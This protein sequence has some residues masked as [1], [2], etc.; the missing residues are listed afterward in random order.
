MEEKI[1]V[2]LKAGLINSS[3]SE[4][5]IR[6]MAKR[7]ALKVTEESQITDDF[8]NDYVEVLKELNGQLSKDVAEIVKKQVEKTTTSQSSAE[9]IE[10]NKTETGFSG[11]G[12]ESPELLKRL[13]KMEREFQE[14]I[15][16]GKVANLKLEAEAKLKLKQATN[17][18]I[19]KN[20]LA[21]V[22][23]A[24]G[25]TADTLAEKVIPIY[26]N[27][28][29]AAFGEGSIPRS[30]ENTPAAPDETKLKEFIKSK[31]IPTEK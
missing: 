12:T 24:D 6:S 1:F 19:L 21:K 7:A 23:I 4:R 20:A 5:T 17:Q 2:K 14:A 16:Q 10:T 15:K 31:G 11:T 27:D 18:Y 22:E 28:Y 26:D 25:D 29:K 13:E 9:Q 8:V 30:G 3:L